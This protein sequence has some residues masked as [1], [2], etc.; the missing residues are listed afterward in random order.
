[1]GRRGKMKNEIIN[2]LKE[3]KKGKKLDAYKVIT[4]VLV[5]ILIICGILL[6]QEYLNRKKA[7]ELYRDLAQ[8]N[9]NPVVQQVSTEKIESSSTETE[10][11]ETATETEIVEDDELEPEVADTTD[12]LAA[13]GIQVPERY[14]DWNKILETNADIYAWL[15]IPGT[16]VDYPILQSSTDDTYYLNHNLDG[17]KGYPGCIYTEMA[18]AKDFSNFNTVIYGHNMKNGTM[19]KSLHD[20]AKADFF[21]SNRYAYIYMPDGKTFVYDLYAVYTFSDKHLL[22]TYSYETVED[23]N[24]YLQMVN[25]CNNESAHFRAGVEVTGD[26]HIITLS[27][28]IS[29]SPKNRFLVQGVL[30]NDEFAD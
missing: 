15:Y 29:G 1:M 13:R 12:P 4:I 19:F 3:F 21:E 14:L 11:I 5:I 10:E 23:R 6:L 27:T 8:E 20:Y 22:N 26:S 17:S 24:N 28:C 16:N 18:N 2:K 30:V 9:R 7:E 25:G